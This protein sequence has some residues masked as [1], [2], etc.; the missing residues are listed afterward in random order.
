MTMIERVARAIYAAMAAPSEP[1]WG[2][3]DEATKHGTK[4]IARAAIKAM[5]EPTEEMVDQASEAIVQE[6][7]KSD[8]EEAKDMAEGLVADPIWHAMID[9]ALKEG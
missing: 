2:C 3:L 9:A 8:W 6:Y 5:R 4:R 1:Y 7:G